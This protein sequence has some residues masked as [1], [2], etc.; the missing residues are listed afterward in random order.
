MKNKLNQINKET[1]SKGKQRLKASQKTVSLPELN[2]EQRE[3]VA[4][5]VEWEKGSYD[6]K[7]IVGGPYQPR[8]D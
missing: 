2:D 7:V 6:P 3:Y 8:V 5:I 1:K 4:K